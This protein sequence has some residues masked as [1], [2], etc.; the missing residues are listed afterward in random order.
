MKCI[1]G[2]KWGVARVIPLTLLVLLII[3]I[4]PLSVLAQGGVA[5]SG[6]FY[7]QNFEIPQGS[8]VSGP[9]IYI[10]VFNNGSEE[11]HVRMSWDAPLGVNVSLS[12]EDFLIEPGEQKKV[13]I[14][15]EVTTEAS[16]GNYT[17]DVTA[18]SYKQEDEGI[19]L[20]GAVGQSADLVVLGDSA[21]VNVQTVSPGGEPV[22]TVIRLYKVIGDENFEVSYSDNGKLEATVSP[23]TYTV[24]CYIGGNNLAEESFQLVA[25]EEKT[26]TLTAA[27]VF[28]EG[29][30]I[31]PNYLAETEELFFAELVYTINNLYQVFPEAKVIL[32]VT[33]EGSS[34]GEMELMTI[35]P[36]E[37]GR[38]GL[39]YNYQPQAGWKQGDYVFNLK[40]YVEDQTYAIS[41]EE[42]LEVAE[43]SASG[44]GIG[45]SGLQWP[46]IGGITFGSMML[47]AA[48]ALPL[49]KRL[50][51]GDKKVT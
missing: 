14:G 7:R 47:V 20:M 46:V 51:K 25:G 27:T 37:K 50:I 42:T 24:G 41:H 31:V 3:S 4:I 39:K 28:F 44:G 9:S 45:R 49:R 35:S 15:V 10:V 19:R 36:L 13:F 40:L 1:S 23:G 11:F 29:F 43:S 26:I 38:V 6:S 17:I 22:I 33:C 12:E 18:E 34:E 16:P 48:I 5:I 2:L 32:D 8:S 30:K 21:S